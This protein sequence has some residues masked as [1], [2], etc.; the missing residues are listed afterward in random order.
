LCF[1]DIFN[2]YV[3]RELPD[4]ILTSDLLSKFEDAAET[5][6]VELTKLLVSELPPCNKHT[7]TWLIIHFTSIIE[8]VSLY[9]PV[10]KGK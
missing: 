5:Q 4:P 6:N 1:T 2:C 3:Y 8:N 7:L 9:V 10:L